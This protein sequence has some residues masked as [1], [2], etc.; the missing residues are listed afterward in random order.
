[1][2]EGRVFL[3]LAAGMG[4]FGVAMGAVL[5]WEMIGSLP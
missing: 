5:I 1:M 3:A 2:A 4:A